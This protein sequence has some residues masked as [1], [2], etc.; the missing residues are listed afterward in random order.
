MKV[1]GQT[2]QAGER[3]KR[4]DGRYQVHYLPRFAV[5]NHVNTIQIHFD[6]EAINTIQIQIDF[7][8]LLYSILDLQIRI[9]ICGHLWYHIIWD[10][11]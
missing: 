1:K 6:F 8:K 4:T 5:D 9:W 7:D 11:F 10:R 3:Y 2:V